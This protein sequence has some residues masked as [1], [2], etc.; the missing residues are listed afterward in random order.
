VSTGI[1]DSQNR[2]KRFA[3]H[4]RAADPVGGAEQVMMVVPVD[5][6]EREAQHV[7]EDARQ[8]VAHRVQAC[9]L[10]RAKLE[11]HDGDDHRH[12]RIAERLDA[13]S[14]HLGRLSGRLLFLCRGEDDMRATQST[15]KKADVLVRANA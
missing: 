10:G 8:L 6:H 15:D 11:R 12:H 3:P 7:H 13:A 14:A 4:R 5:P 9:A 1:S 2:R